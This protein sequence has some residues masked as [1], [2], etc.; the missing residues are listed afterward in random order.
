[1]RCS[2]DGSQPHPASMY[3]PRSRGKRSYTPCTIIDSNADCA[4]W[5]CTTVCHS[6]NV[7][8]R[9]LPAL[10][11]LRPMNSCVANAQ[12]RSWSSS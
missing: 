12:S 6:V 4:S 7:A 2:H 1:M 10:A 3:A 5:L 8:K 9:S 11:A